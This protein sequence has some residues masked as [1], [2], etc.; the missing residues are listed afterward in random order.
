[1]VNVREPKPGTRKGGSRAKFVHRV[2]M[3]GGANSGSG[4]QSRQVKSGQVRSGQPESVPCSVE[5]FPTPG[6]LCAGREALSLAQMP[7]LSKTALA[8]RD[9]APGPRDGDAAGRDK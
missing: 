3:G 7:P 8:I 2:N 9:L 5:D 6:P 1:M 4:S